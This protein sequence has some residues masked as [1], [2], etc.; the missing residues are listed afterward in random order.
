MRT[1]FGL[2]LQFPS[3]LQGLQYFSQVTVKH[4][5]LGLSRAYRASVCFENTLAFAFSPSWRL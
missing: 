1:T 5:W 2:T 3:R 4:Q